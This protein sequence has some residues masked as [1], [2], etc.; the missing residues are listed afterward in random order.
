MRASSAKIRA[1]GVTHT[2]EVAPLYAQRDAARCY[3]A[4]ASARHVLRAS[5]ARLCRA[6]QRQRS[7][8]ARTRDTSALPRDQPIQHQQIDRCMPSVLMPPL[9]LPE[10]ARRA[11]RG[12]AHV[13]RE[14]CRARARR[15]AVPAARV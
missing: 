3:C 10:C 4:C 14:R 2:Y 6:S 1:R 12:Y 9:M 13:M 5:Y 8:Y 11:A 15:A 7:R